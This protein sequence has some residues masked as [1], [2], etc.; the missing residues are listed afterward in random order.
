MACW[1]DCS[2]TNSIVLR[3]I[4][5]IVD[6]QRGCLDNIL[7]IH[8]N[9]VR[10][11]VRTDYHQGPAGTSAPR[12]A[13][14]YRDVVRLT[15]SRA[16]QCNGQCG[17]RKTDRSAPCSTQSRLQMTVYVSSV[18]IESEPILRGVKFQL[19]FRLLFIGPSIKVV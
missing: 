10:P 14:A 18:C 9:C 16:L 12:V 5:V 6:P 1:K 13:V 15:T 3:C 8:N 7:E 2:P 17:L 19:C 11:P 4:I